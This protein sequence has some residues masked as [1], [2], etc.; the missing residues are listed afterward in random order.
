MIKDEKAYILDDVQK[1]V[2][3]SSYVKHLAKILESIL[4]NGDENI[5]DTSIATLS[6]L[7]TRTACATSNKINKLSL[8]L[9]KSLD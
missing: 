4:N 1:I 3:E 9:E 7:L 6:G 2:I 8:R 5:S